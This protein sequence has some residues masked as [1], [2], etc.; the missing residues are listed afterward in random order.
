MHDCAGYDLQVASNAWRFLQPGPRGGINSL[1][2]RVV[3]GR[4]A[5]RIVGWKALQNKVEKRSV[6]IAFDP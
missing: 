4:K 5:C 2:G 3:N 6:Q 1:I